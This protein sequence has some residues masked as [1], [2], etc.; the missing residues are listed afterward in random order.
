MSETT[1]Q[2]HLAPA[3]GRSLTRRWITAPEAGLII[4]ILAFGALLAFLAGTKPGPTATVDLPPGVTTSEKAETS[5]DG[6]RRSVLVIESTGTL[7]FTRIEQ[8]APRDPNG[9]LELASENVRVRF[10]PPAR[11]L[12]KGRQA[13]IVAGADPNNAIRL[14]RAVVAT[15]PAGKGSLL[16]L[17]NAESDR[18]L[19]E[20][21]R[22]DFPADPSGN[23]LVNTA[24]GPVRLNAG[25]DLLLS[26]ASPDT[27]RLTTRPVNKFLAPDNLV[28]LAKDASFIAVMAVGMTFVL[29]LGGI[30]LSVGSVYALAAAVGAILLRHR[31]E[32][33]LPPVTLAGAS[34]PLAPLALAVAGMVVAGG[35]MR[36]ASPRVPGVHARTVARAGLVTLALA[37]ITFLVLAAVV[38]TAVRGAYSGVGEADPD[39]PRLASLTIGLVSCV[40]TGA[41][42]GMVSGALVVGLRVHP[43]IITLGMMELLRGLVFLLGKGQTI[44]GF[45]ESFTSG[46]FKADFGGQIY[47]VPV[48][49]MLAVAL[50]GLVLLGRTVFGRRC[51]A[52]G[53]NETAA[54]YAGVPVGRTKILAFTLCGALAGLSAAM[55]LGYLGAA[56]PAAGQGY[57]LNVIAAAVIGGVSLSG[58]RGSV[59]GAVLGAILVQMI[60]NAIVILDIDNSYFRVVMGAAIVAAVVLDQLKSRL[61][62]ARRS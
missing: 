39:V 20:S 21:L 14:G 54:Q 18:G 13:S 2:A 31:W 59:L 62:K 16:T 52:I 19:I 24:R 28:L 53:G 34:L 58:G 27:L 56:E 23:L 45:P 33:G 44:S 1:P 9:T 4:V 36:L 60:T 22:E 55:Y 10:A 7:P 47:P 29:V 49:F 43:F 46:F 37:A 61:G 35:I 15:Q 11:E 42:C 48:F 8:L 57:E 17:D 32:T 51:F 6:T 3:R 25:P 41:L 12:R 50:A 40:V 38:V 30:D 26:P 5:P